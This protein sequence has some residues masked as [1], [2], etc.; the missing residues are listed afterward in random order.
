[1]LLGVGALAIILI[2]LAL[3]YRYAPRTVPAGQP[4]LRQLDD[5]AHGLASLKEEFNEAADAQRLLVLLSP[6]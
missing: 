1:L 4:P 3:A 5:S 2:A 6:T